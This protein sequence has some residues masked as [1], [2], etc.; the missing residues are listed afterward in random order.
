MLKYLHDKFA[1]ANYA[2][3]AINSD[4]TFVVKKNKKTRIMSKRDTKSKR[5]ELN[6]K[7]LRMIPITEKET[8]IEKLKGKKYHTSR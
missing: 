4:N 6:Q 7:E 8:K 1:K 3:N 5:K 2:R